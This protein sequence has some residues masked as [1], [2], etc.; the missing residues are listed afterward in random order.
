MKKSLTILLLFLI[1]IPVFAQSQING[2]VTDKDQSPLIGATVVIKGTTDGSIT[3]Y[4]GKFSINAN[5]EDVLE[6][7]YIGYKPQQ[8]TVGNQTSF[9][10]V[11][12][13]D[14][15]ALEEVVVIGYG[16]AK[17]KDLT[18][19]IALVD[20]QEM[21]KVPASNVG[22]A[23]Q[24][25]MSGVQVSS[26]SEPGSAPNITIR[27]VGTI[28]GDKS[29]LVIIDGIQTVVGALSQIN[30]NDIESMQVLKD[31][32]AAAIYGSRAANG[33][34]I[35]TTKS[36]K[37]GKLKV[38]IS[39]ESGVTSVINTMEMMGTSRYAQYTKKLYENSE[40]SMP[41]PQWVNDAEILKTNTD[42]QS[43]YFRPARM[44][45]YSVSLHGG[46]EKASIYTS[47]G[48]F[49]QEGNMPSKDFERLTYRVN[50]SIKHGAF[51]FGETLNINV[52][53]KD[54]GR[55]G[56]NSE[57]FFAAPQMPV[58]DSE[59]LNGLGKPT[60][61]LTGGNNAPNPMVHELYDNWR[62]NFGAIGNLYGEATI[63]DGLIFRSD[64]NFSYDS[65]YHEEYLIPVDQGMAA[66]IS[67]TTYDIQQINQMNYSYNWENYFRY[68]KT[69]GK[70]IVGGMV[71]MT[72]NEGFIRRTVAIG[73]DLEPGIRSAQIGVSS[74]AMSDRDKFLGLHSY[75]GRVNYSY[76][77][78]YLFTASARRD[79]YF[80]FSDAHKHGVFP[81]FSMGWRVS[82]EAFMQTLDFIS[83]LKIRGGYGALGRNMGRNDTRMQNTIRYPWE[84]GS[85]IG[86]GPQGVANPNLKWETVTQSNFGFDAE[87]LEGQFAITG[88]YFVRRSKDMIIQLDPPMNTGIFEGQWTN[89][90]SMSN[91][92]V[93]FEASWKIKTEGGFNHTLSVNATHIKNNLE[94]LADTRPEIVEEN[95]ILRPGSPVGAIYG[96]RVD[97]D[98]YPTGIN[99]E[100]GNIA[101]KDLDNSGGVDDADREIL[102]SPFPDWFF[103]LNYAA[104][105]KNFDLTIF[106]Q[107]QTG[108][109]IING[110]K[111]NLGG[112]N[113]DRNRLNWVLDEAYDPITNPNGTAPKISMSG[114][115]AN[116][117]M[118][119]YFVENG[120]FVRVRNIQ[121]GYSI[122]SRILEK[123]KMDRIRVYANII[124]PFTFTNYTGMDPSLN[125]GNNAD[126]FNLAYDNYSYPQTM[127]VNFGANISF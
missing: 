89:V 101:Y 123:I 54:Y 38:D 84:S 57:I 69:F 83:N 39:L 72:V 75:L 20:P 66:H 73:N 47:F 122:P 52:N 17:K 70:H 26:S 2:Q 110:A 22:T 80:L 118:S 32:S 14:V 111:R 79:G 86:V 74:Q 53:Q 7:T 115:A 1:S 35:V 105:Y 11:L 92:G 33:V 82:E 64:F 67:R 104:S 40:P 102:G 106:I 44:Q 98:T 30:G 18:G 125:K 77:D 41:A 29:P 113:R 109:S 59:N 5:P 116:D 107:G 55:Y 120:S 90:G 99:P 117:L 119:D 112:T 25:R 126:V 94:H 91:K 10:F 23:L 97:Y 43:E 48:Y 50:S 37:G 12:E 71:G 16:T 108:N 65:F 19:S 27:G 100:T 61:G 85:M 88:D 81:S 103:G 13:E 76:D 127:S 93:E 15:E 68:N 46:T 28:Y 21:Q 34:I 96:R 9:S 87:F 3:D 8:T 95:A 62:T 56:G 45:N 121:L 78:K 63:F 124:N 49:S 31:A 6:I 4:E 51:K 114:N 36:G 60:V 24:G 42:W 58:Y